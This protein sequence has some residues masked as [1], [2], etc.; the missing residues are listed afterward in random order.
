MFGK[1]PHAQPDSALPRSVTYPL[2][3][4]LAL[5]CSTLALVA[6]GGGGSSDNPT[7]QPPPVSTL[8]APEN[9][10]VKNITEF[11]W[12]PTPGATR[13]ELYA[14]P[15]GTGP[16]PETKVDDFNAASGTG[17]QYGQFGAQGFMGNLYGTGTASAMAAMLN[18]TYRLRACDANGCG[19]FTDPKASNIANDVSREFASGRVPLN[20]S[21]GFA[22]DPRLSKDG[23]TLAINSPR[24]GTDGAVYVFTRTGTAQPWEVHSEI[25]SGKSN[26][27]RRTALSADGSTLAVSALEPTSSDP[28]VSGVVY[29]YQRS[30]ATWT[31]QWLLAAPDAPAACTQPCRAGSLDNLALSADGN[32]LAASVNYS[33]AAGVG[34]IS[35]GAVATFARNGATWAQQSLL[36]TGGKVASSLA[37]SSDGSTLAVNE[38]A[39][40]TLPETLTTTTPFVR[41]FSQQ[42]GSWTQQARLPAGIVGK[43]DISGSQYSAMALSSDG[44]T[45]AVHAINVPGHQT[46]ELDIKPADLSCGA[47]KDGWYVGLYTRNGATWQRQTAISRGLAGKWALAA[48]GNAL[49]Y[50]NALFTR[51]GNTWAC[52]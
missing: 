6:C 14:D 15:D 32:L 1:P 16:Q 23:L 50:G 44:S 46:P 22:A 7:P 36:E 3:T 29:L 31:Q 39:L 17:F 24:A 49:F 40:D 4:A 8:A 51:S 13:Y 37:L 19:G 5:G 41:I 47:M 11:S 2:R 21:N 30:G 43:T 18:S 38:G 25:R 45:L 20:F 9:F 12:S 28:N 42:G 48:D 34:N 33:T 35:L 26:F 52:P 10:A 27:A